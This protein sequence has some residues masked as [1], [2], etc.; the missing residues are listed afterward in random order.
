[1]L[2]LRINPN[3]TMD[4]LRTIIKKIP[5]RVRKTAEATRNSRIVFSTRVRNA[6][7]PKMWLL[8]PYY[9][10]MPYPESSC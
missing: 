4:L 10:E 3:L 9:K 8:Q 7:V 6:C 5:R 1:M 2:I